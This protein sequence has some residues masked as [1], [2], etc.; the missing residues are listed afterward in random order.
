[1]N[2]AWNTSGYKTQ[3]WQLKLKVNYRYAINVPP[4]GEFHENLPKWNKKK[5]F[6]LVKSVIF[7]KAVI[8]FLP[9]FTNCLKNEL[10]SASDL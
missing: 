1:M 10:T 7:P 5:V 4:L 2:Y 6:L 9:T 8:S 3:R